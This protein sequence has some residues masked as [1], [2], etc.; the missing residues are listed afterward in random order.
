MQAP[1]HEFPRQNLSASNDRDA[2]SI[3]LHRNVETQWPLTSLEAISRI[4]AVPASLIAKPNVTTMHG[5]SAQNHSSHGVGK[6]G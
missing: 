6:R 1:I 4:A 5:A 2:S 3:G